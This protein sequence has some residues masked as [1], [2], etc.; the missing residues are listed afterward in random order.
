MIGDKSGGVGRREFSQLGDVVVVPQ[1][2]SAV[3]QPNEQVH[4]FAFP[5]NCCP[6]SCRVHEIAELQSCNVFRVN[7]ERHSRRGESD[8][9][10]T[11]PLPLQHEVRRQQR[12]VAFPEPDIAGQPPKFGL[13]DR[14]LKHRDRR[15][16]IVI[17]QHHRM[18]AQPIHGVDHGQGLPGI[19]A[20]M[21]EVETGRIALNRV[22]CIHQHQARMLAPQFPQHGPKVRQS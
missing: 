18:V 5:E 10:H 13:R 17:A 11:H 22:A 1:V 8:D 15:L 9:P 16:E 6:L 21:T 7:P 19:R 4:L 2:V 12:T 20:N 3:K 14:L